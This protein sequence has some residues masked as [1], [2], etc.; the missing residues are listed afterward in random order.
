[1]GD[2]GAGVDAAVA[3][4]LQGF[5][6]ADLAGARPADLAPGA[7]YATPPA[8]GAVVLEVPA[9]AV[10][11]G[12]VAWTAD[13]TAA[14]SAS[15]AGA[16]RPVGA[17]EPR[18]PALPALAVAIAGAAASIDAGA[19]LAIAV[20]HAGFA[21][22]VFF[23]RRASVTHADLAPGTGAPPG[24][25]APGVVAY[26]AADCVAGAA[27]AATGGP[28]PLAAAIAGA[29]A[30]VRALVVAAG[31]AGI[32]PADWHVRADPFAAAQGTR[33]AGPPAGAVAAASLRAEVTRAFPG[34]AAQGAIRA[35]AAVT[36][37]T[38]IPGAAL[39]VAAA[40]ATAAAA[41]ATPERCAGA[42]RR[43]SALSP[44]AGPGRGLGVVGRIALGVPTDGSVAVA[45]AAPVS[46][47][48][49]VGPAGLRPLVLADPARRGQAAGGALVENTFLDRQAAAAGIGAGAEQT[50]AGA[51]AFA[52]DSVDT[53]LGLA[54]LVAAA[55][56]AEP[57]G[58][59]AALDAGGGAHALI[60]AGTARQADSAL[61]RGRLAR[62]TDAGD[63]GSLAVAHA[64]GHELV[65]AVAARLPAD[66]AG[67]IFGAAAL[68]IADAALTAGVRR[69]APADLVR[70]LATG[71]DR[72]AL[73]RP[74]G[75]IAGDAGS[76]AG[77]VAADAVGAGLAET[78]VVA[79][80]GRAERP[81]RAA[82]RPGAA[83]LPHAVAG[84]A[85]DVAIAGVAGRFRRFR[86]GGRTAD[87]LRRA[88]APG[89]RRPDHP[90]APGIQGRPPVGREADRGGVDRLGGAAD[91]SPEAGPRKQESH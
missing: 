75:Q 19:G 70:V 23:G 80:A 43:R 84:R 49:A 85:L 22:V 14:A 51:G 18:G 20:C 46:V 69:V 89:A 11:V 41:A 16:P 42:W 72:R 40:A 21:R 82:G 90:G 30:P 39:A 35:L 73:T 37:G 7:T 52:A 58:A 76:G 62:Q 78:L 9:L 27:G 77:D 56:L 65:R 17:R 50:R 29:V 53:R 60:V 66:G 71:R 64:G 13:A 12:P 59:A 24:F 33:L 44:P 57:L 10:A 45:L 3:A 32:S 47:T 31:T 68:A 83:D 6:A 28:R 26:P 86:R 25:A 79:L 55:V 61:A 4:D 91:A 48:A 87:R 34:P 5:I 38:H 54:L 74:L 8:V 1:M 15:A 2:V 67:G 63:T 81:P 88:G 36:A